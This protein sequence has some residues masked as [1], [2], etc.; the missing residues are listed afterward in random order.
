MLAEADRRVRVRGRPEAMLRRRPPGAGHARGATRRERERFFATL[1]LGMAL[2]Y[3]GDGEEGAGRCARR[4]TILERSDALSGDPRLLVVGRA[5]RRCG[6]ARPQRGPRARRARDRVGARAGRGRRAAVLALA[7]RRATRRRATGRGRGR[8]LRGGD[9]ARARDGAGDVAVR[10]AGGPGV[11][12]GPPGPRGAAASTPRRRSRSREQL[13]LA[14][15]RL[16]ALDALAELE[17]GP[18]ERRAGDRAAA[19]RRS[20]CSPS[21]ASPTPT[22][23]PCPSSSRRCCGSTAPRHA[24]RGL[25]A[26]RRTPR[27]SRGRSRG[28]RAAARRATYD[29]RGGAAPARADAR[30]LRGGPH[31]ALPRRGAAPRAGARPGARAAAP[32]RRRVRRA[33][34]RARGPSARGASCQASGET[35]RRRDPRT[36]DQ[37]TPRELQVALV[38]RRGPHDPRGGGEAV[39]QPEDRRLPPAPR[40]PQARRSARAPRWPTPLRRATRTPS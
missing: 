13:G 28:S 37:L 8:A 36:L 18:R 20:S 39:P 6:C 3:T 22:C 23:R 15:F 12:R 25:R 10:R 9:P 27:A 19:R 35:A 2:I 33:R 32:R 21:A 30:P 4:S 40:L 11:R 16:W 31:P 17:L 7:R 1:A 34:R 24:A 29:V 5:R 14:F 38:A 26:R